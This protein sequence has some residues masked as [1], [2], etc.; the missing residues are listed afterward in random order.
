MRN[1]LF[2]TL[3]AVLTLPISMAE[4]PKG[5]MNCVDGSVDSKNC[6]LTSI[7]P[8]NRQTKRKDALPTDLIVHY[9]YSDATGNGKAK[10]LN[11]NTQLHSGDK[12]T[13]KLEAREPLYV[14]LFHFDSH[15]QLNELLHLSGQKDN[16]LDAGEKITLPADDRHFLLDDHSGKETIHTIVSPTPLNQLYTQYRQKIL[17]DNMLASAVPKGIIVGEDQDSG[18]QAGGTGSQTKPSTGRTMACLAGN[19]CRDSFV[20]LHLQ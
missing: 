18:P 15:R 2:C 12:F 1:A 19:A 16:R 13:V 4:E 10:P 9:R 3:L 8:D 20:I 5:I 6:I 17:G 11:N 14:Y 7:N